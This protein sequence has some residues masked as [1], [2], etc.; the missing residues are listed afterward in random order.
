[1]VSIPDLY[2]TWETL[3]TD[4]RAMSAWRALP[5]CPTM[6]THPTSNARADVHRRAAVRTRVVEY[7]AVLAEVCA[8]YPR[9][10]TDGGAA[11]RAPVVPTE[12]SIRDYWHPN[13]AGQAALAKLVWDTLGY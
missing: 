6:F 11:F 2:R 8:T 13:I 1:V 3:H 10:T 7:N 9:C 12:F 4:A 5:F